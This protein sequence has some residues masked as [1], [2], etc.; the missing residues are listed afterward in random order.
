MPISNVILEQLYKNSPSFIQM[1]LDD[2]SINDADIELLTAHF[3]VNSNVREVL[4]LS[5]S[6]TANS[7]PLLLELVKSHPNIT[8]L[9]FKA[10]MPLTVTGAM[11]NRAINEVTRENLTKQQKV[12]YED[13]LSG[14]NNLVMFSNFDGNTKKPSQKSVLLTKP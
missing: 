13:N 12:N 6:L 4:I 3:P 10:I 8:S 5:H 9:R 2:L 1:R 7:Y 14:P 11:Y